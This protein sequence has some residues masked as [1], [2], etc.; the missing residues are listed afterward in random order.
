MSGPNSA[1]ASRPRLA[2]VA[3]TYP[4]LT[5]TFVTGE[6]RELCRIGECPLVFGVLRGDGDLEGAPP[7]RYVVELP[8]HRQLA[9]LAALLLRRPRRTLRAL[10]RAE[11]RFGGT[12]RD[13][14]AVAP[15]AL[16]LRGVTHIHAHFASQPTDVAGRL[17]ELT[18]IPFSFT[19]HARDIYVEW[20]RMDRKLAAARF[21][22]TVCDY[23]RRYILERVPQ[24][25]AKLHVLICGVDVD[26]FRRRRPY[27]AEG[28]LVAVGRLVEQKGFHHLVQAAAAARDA[29]R[30]VLIAGEGPERQR[31]ERLVADLRAP[32]RLL[33]PVSHERVRDLYE[34]ASAA[35][36]PCVV[37][38]DGSR[39]SMPVSLKEAMA[40]ELPV[41]ATE[42]VGVPELVAAERGLLV[43]PGDTDALAAALA[44]LTAM[45]AE[46]RHAMGRAGREF[47]VERCNLRTETLRLG[48]LFPPSAIRIAPA[49]GDPD[50][51][52]GRG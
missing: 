3:G 46:E 51:R 1:R 34:S 35:V 41:V 33:G 50:A 26:V 7:A 32:V 16:A 38:R 42:E 48:R 49:E 2:Y 52:E 29:V 37:A 31:L 14:A 13:M 12:A 24:A 8:K 47:V 25:A 43:P 27:A 10:L 4:A 19:A 23:N 39:D 40:L 36:L 44:E 17:S 18:G 30:E 11:R 22:V 45:P 28:P 21:A 6:L 15:L 9:A 20:E 5:E